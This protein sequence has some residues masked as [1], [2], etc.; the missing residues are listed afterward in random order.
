MRRRVLL[1]ANDAKQKVR[2]ALPT[3]RQFLADH[4]VEIVDEL[5]HPDVA[6]STR[7]RDADLLLVLGGDGT[8]LEWAR[9]FVDHELPILGVNFGKLGYLAEFD[10]RSLIDLGPEIFARDSLPISELIVMEATVHPP[11]TSHPRFCG[12]AINDCVITAGRPFRMIDI[13]LTIDGEAGPLLTGD[14]VIVSTPI[15]TTAYNVAAGGPI[16]SPHVEALTI[17]PLAAHS[18][19]TRPVVVSANRAIEMELQGTNPGTSL[20]LDGQIH[21]IL[22]TGERIR[23]ARYPK[24]AK[25]VRNPAGSYWKTLLTKMGWSARLAP[26]ARDADADSPPPT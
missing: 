13:S 11:L 1:L 19:A 17:T 26:P 18:L 21:H 10:L 15:G 8:L 2:N 22:Q 25:L 9:K 16:V 3:V 6:Q 23:L 24:S 12:T 7:T 14:G 5:T 4:E 20:V